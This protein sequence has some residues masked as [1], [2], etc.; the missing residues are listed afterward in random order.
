MIM[1]LIMWP[2]KEVPQLYIQAHLLK[3]G[4]DP[5]PVLIVW[6]TGFQTFLYCSVYWFLCSL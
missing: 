5:V 3:I 4:Q 6:Y 1:S 2:P